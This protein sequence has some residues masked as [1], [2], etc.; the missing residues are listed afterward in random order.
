MLYTTEIITREIPAAELLEKYH[1]PEIVLP[2]C[3]ECPDYAHIWSCPPGTPSADIFKKFR[4]AVIIGIKV[5]YSEEALLKA[6]ESE[7]ST[8]A[9]R[10]ETY[11]KVKRK[12]FGALLKAEK[13]SPPSYTIA[14]GRCELCRRCARLDGLF[15]RNPWALRY[16]FSAFGFDMGRISDELLNTPLL[17]TDKGLPK[18][19][20]AI[21]AF[22]TNNEK[23]PAHK[24]EEPI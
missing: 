6:E 1:I 5:I 8:E 16:S 22:L 20:M 17:W 12:V 15:C 2:L 4:Y 18:Y 11:G 21:Y 9:V 19:N 23:M 24:T 13:M 14:A 10:A 7:E 3:K